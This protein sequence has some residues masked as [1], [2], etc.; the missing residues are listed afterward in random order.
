MVNSGQKALAYDWKGAK[1]EDID[2]KW[3]FKPD[4]YKAAILKEISERGLVPLEKAGKEFIEEHSFSEVII[5]DVRSLV[6]D[7]LESLKERK[8]D[9]DYSH[10]TTTK[11]A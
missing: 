9:N 4:D 1:W 5:E 10:T 3:K 6:I 7:W 2:S 11:R 8:G